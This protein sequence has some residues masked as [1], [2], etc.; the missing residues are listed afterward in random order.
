MEIDWKAIVDEI[1]TLMS[2]RLEYYVDSNKEELKAY[3]KDIAKSLV[4]AIRSGR[5]DL[6][7]EIYEQIEM[8]AEIHRIQLNRE[9]RDMMRSVLE[10]GMRIGKVAIATL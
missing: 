3:G 2:D 9:A 7:A 5:A 4:I 1:G 6:Q 10:I 8:I